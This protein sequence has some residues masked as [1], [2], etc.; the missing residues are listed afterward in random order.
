MIDK[1]H[2]NL[3][4]EYRVCS[5]LL[6]RGL[7]AT[8]TYGN[9]KGADIYVIGQGRRAAVVEVK[10][11]NSLRF[12]TGF[13]QKYKTPDCEHPDFWVL[14]SIAGECD[15][16]FVLSHS[17]MAIVQAKRNGDAGLSWVDCATSVA[18]G[19]DNVL[20]AHVAEFENQW[21]KIVAHL[22]S[23]GVVGGSVDA[24]R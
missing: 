7:F 2:L 9:R 12:V 5:E 18:Q 22:E 24:D 23:P 11:S 8:V 14:Y 20:A 4:G 10:S 19:V 21:Q 17:E 6:K 1:Y 3:A 16:F 15:R 13:Y